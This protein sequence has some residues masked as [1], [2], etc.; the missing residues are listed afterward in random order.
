MIKSSIAFR[1]CEDLIPKKRASKRDEVL[2]LLYIKFWCIVIGST[3]GACRVCLSS[4]TEYSTGYCKRF[5][6]FEQEC[7]KCGNLFE[8]YS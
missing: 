7:G 1:F 2:S 6:Y 8:K 4:C 3:L 5:T